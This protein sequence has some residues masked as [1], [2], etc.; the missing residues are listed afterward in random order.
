M[1]DYY[2]SPLSLQEYE[3]KMGNPFKHEGHGAPAAPGGHSESG[4]GAH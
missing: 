3:Q 2:S 1:P 4:K